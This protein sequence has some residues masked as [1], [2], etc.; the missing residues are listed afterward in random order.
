MTGRISGT[1]DLRRYVIVLVDAFTKFVYLHYILKIDSSS[2]IKATKSAIFI[3][4][5]PIHIIADQGRC[6]TDKE[7]QNFCE[8]K[9]I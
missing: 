6:F 5:K 4:S 7:F 8:G 1:I 3:F 2:T 9:N